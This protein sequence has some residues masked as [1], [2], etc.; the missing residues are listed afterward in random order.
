MSNPCPFPGAKRRLFRNNSIISSCEQRWKVIALNAAGQDSLCFLHISCRTTDL[1]CLVLSV[2]TLTKLSVASS[3]PPS[4]YVHMSRVS[5]PVLRTTTSRGFTLDSWWRL[6]FLF[7][8]EKLIPSLEQGM[9]DVTLPSGPCARAGR[10]QFWNLG[11]AW[12]PGF[13]ADGLTTVR[14]LVCK[15]SGGWVRRHQLKWK[16]RPTKMEGKLLFYLQVCVPQQERAADVLAL[17]IHFFPTLIWVSK[18]LY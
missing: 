8:P 11:I 10:P 1:T 17:N 7:Q 2:P 16:T 6:R 4:Q 15:V 9:W 18:M 13:S 14:H 12:V 5:Q 3:L